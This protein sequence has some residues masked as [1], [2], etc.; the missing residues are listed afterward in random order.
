MWSAQPVVAIIS[1]NVDFKS[2]IQE[3]IKD[4]DVCHAVRGHE[5]AIR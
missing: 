1:T 2:L 5:A 4:G 3:H